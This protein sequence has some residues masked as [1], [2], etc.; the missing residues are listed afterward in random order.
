MEMLDD[1]HPDLFFFLF[2]SGINMC[3]LIGAAT[4]GSKPGVNAILAW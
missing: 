3:L 1:V 4:K 2:I